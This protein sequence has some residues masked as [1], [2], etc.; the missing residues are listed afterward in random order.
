L[1]KNASVDYTKPG[2]CQCW[3][4]VSLSTTQQ[5]NP[6]LGLKSVNFDHEIMEIGLI[7]SNFIE[8]APLQNQD[9]FGYVSEH[10]TSYHTT[11]VVS[12][13]VSFS[14]KDPLLGWEPCPKWKCM[15]HYMK[16]DLPL[17]CI[18]VLVL[19]RGSMHAWFLPK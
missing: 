17:H 12:H 2:F 14:S 3:I 16:I 15:K 13:W 8:K 5:K 10:E 11:T 1:L 18:V 6:P 9:I 19:S 4:A 7:C